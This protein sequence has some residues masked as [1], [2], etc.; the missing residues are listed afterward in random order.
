MA[1]DH[2]PVHQHRSWVV[3]TLGPLAALVVV[4]GV[5]LVIEAVAIGHTGLALG[6]GMWSGAT[7]VQRAPAGSEVVFGNFP[8]ARIEQIAGFRTGSVG[9]DSAMMM[10]AIYERHRGTVR[11]P[12]DT[13]LIAVLE[14]VV[15]WTRPVTVRVLPENFPARGRRLGRI[16]LRPGGPVVPLYERER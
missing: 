16:V 13:G 9:A 2:S 7:N 8:I 5:L 14:P 10:L 3:Y 1:N 11:I 4:I 15:D 12:L 6:R